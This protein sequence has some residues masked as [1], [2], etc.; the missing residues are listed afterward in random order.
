[1][2]VSV[3]ST[4]KF[5][6]NSLY[7]VLHRTPTNDPL[8][9]VQQTRRQNGFEAWHAIGR[10]H[11]QR[12]MSENNSAHAALIS[13]I[14]ERDRAKDVEQFNDILRTFINE[15]NI[16]DNSFD[17]IRDAE[18]LTVKKLVFESLLT[19][20]F[21]GTTMSYDELLIALGNVIHGQGCNIPVS[22]KL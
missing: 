10:I 9:L 18:M 12:N 2:L 11:D 6:N 3:E 14:F 15:T 1:M 19:F 22:Q 5:D 4:D 16:F 20:R 13:D 17:T 7:Q 8:V 21:R